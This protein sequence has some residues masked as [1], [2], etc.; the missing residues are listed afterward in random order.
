MHPH[1]VRATTL[2]QWIH[3]STMPSLSPTHALFCGLLLATACSETVNP[4]HASDDAAEA[5]MAAQLANDRPYTVSDVALDAALADLCSVRSSI[6]ID[7]T[8]EDPT[9]KTWLAALASCVTSGPL[10]G[11]SLEL[12]AHTSAHHDSRYARR[13]G[14]SRAESLRAMLVENGVPQSEIRSSAAVA[15]DERSIEVRVVPRHAR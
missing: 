10:Q 14:E 9:S 6:E 3:L 8:H 5:E 11:R 13:L 4:D 7:P 2:V 15:G 12:I 1:S